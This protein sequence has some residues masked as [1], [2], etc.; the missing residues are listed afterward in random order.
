MD[1]CDILHIVPIPAETLPRRPLLREDVLA[2]L[3]DAIVDGTLARL[4]C[5]S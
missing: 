4:E 3:R 2:R 5:A 1:I